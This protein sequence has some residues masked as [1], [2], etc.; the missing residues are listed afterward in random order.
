MP[1]PYGDDA[2]ETAVKSTAAAL[3]QWDGVL[4]V[5]GQHRRWWERVHFLH[6]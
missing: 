6:G 1:D 3:R 2:E 4:A 5:L